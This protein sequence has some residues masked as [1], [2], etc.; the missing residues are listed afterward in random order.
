MF[1]LQFLGVAIGG[2][3][4]RSIKVALVRRWAGTLQL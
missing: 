4:K 1:V 2:I 3:L